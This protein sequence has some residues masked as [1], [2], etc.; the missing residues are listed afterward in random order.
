MDMIQRQK[1]SMAM[2]EAVG[3]GLYQLSQALPDVRRD[4]GNN[5]AGSMRLGG[6]LLSWVAEPADGLTGESMVLNVFVCGPGENVRSVP[7]WRQFITDASKQVF[8]PYRPRVIGLDAGDD[9]MK[10]E[11]LTKYCFDEF[12]SRSEE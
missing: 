1:T 11:Q 10:V 6:L 2:V 4:S 9:E 3:K 12:L 8:V 7:P 5:I